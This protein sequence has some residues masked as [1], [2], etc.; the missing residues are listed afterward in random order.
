EAGD[1]S[2]ECIAV[3]QTGDATGAWYRYDFHLTSFFQDY[4]KFGVWPDGYYMSSNMFIGC[5]SCF[6]GPQA[7]VF[8][9]SKMLIGDPTA[10]A[11]P[12]VRIE[13]ASPFL[14]SDLDVILPPP[15]GDPNHFVEVVVPES[16]GPEEQ[17]LAV[18]LATPTP[19][20][21]PALAYKVWA[22]HVDWD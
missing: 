14:P 6:R 8:D 16:E 11:Q 17:Q 22:F 5:F 3:S 7:F 19:T 13:S 20:A 2:D 12:P 21:T 15:P 1:N 9:R 10:T 18:P 4:P